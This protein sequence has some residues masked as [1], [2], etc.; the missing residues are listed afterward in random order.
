M[1]SE[2]D[3][4]SAQRGSGLLSALSGGETV[5]AKDAATVS[6]AGVEGTQFGRYR[7]IKLL[8]RGGMGEVWRGY[9]TGTD[10]TVAIKLL[11]ANFSD[12]EEFKQRFRREARAAAGL[13]TPHVIP[14]YDYGEID[15]HL[16]V[17]MRLIEGRDLH[18]VLADGPMEPSRAVHIIEQVAV[19][20]RAAHVV[21]LLHRDVKPSNILLDEDDFAYLIDFGIA[22]A[23]D[24]TTRLTQSGNT[25]GT[26]H[27]IAPERLDAEAEEDARADIY[28]LACVLYEC[29]TGRP[30]FDEHTM[31]RLVAAHLNTP[32]PRP[33]TGHPNVPAAL[34][35]VIATGMAKDPEQRYA[36]TVELADAARDAISDLIQKSPQPAPRRSGA[37]HRTPRDRRMDRRTKITLIAGAVAVV[38]IVVGVVLAAGLPSESPS[39]TTGPSSRAPGSSHLPSP[40]PAAPYGSQA[41]LPFSGLNG[42]QGV[43]VD[44]AANVYV[45]DAANHRVLK[46]PAG[47][48][49]QEVLPFS[50]LNDPEGVAVDSAADVYVADPAAHQV[51]KLPAGSSTEEVLPFSALDRITDVAVDSD[52]NLYAADTV[53]HRVLKLPA[54]ASTPEVLPFSGLTNPEGVDV[55]SAGNVYVADT[56][57]HRVLKLPAGSSTQEVLPFSGLNDP[58]E[59]AVDSAANVYVADTANHRVLK[60]PAGSSTQEVLSFSGLFYPEGV[61]VDPAGNVYVSDTSNRRILKLPAR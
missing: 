21:G 33:S 5:A 27:Y 44:S 57:N 47:S 31:P 55:D 35:P 39:R 50:N 36:T 24:E 16:Y 20:L 37:V 32:P 54:G 49:T 59:V 7:L 18:S 53:N 9:D 25:I 29:L 19:A 3:E 22:R 28:S 61:A 1:Q 11:P 40:K 43:A 58:E 52:A 12:H 23:I 30:P 13:N 46:L 34:D 42:P 26:I 14:I 38:A 51:L 41:V 17:C 2:P 15:G 60:L 48:S 8:G 6:E 4:R 10:R 45:A 56:A